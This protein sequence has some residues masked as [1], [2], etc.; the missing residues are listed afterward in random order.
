[1][2]P[3]VKRLLPPASSSGA[4][5]STSTD[6]P[7]SA[8]ANAAQNAALPAPITTTSHEEGRAV[9]MNA[10]RDSLMAHRTAQNGRGHCG[11][12][13]LVHAAAVARN[14]NA[15]ALDLALAGFAAQLHDELVNLDRPGGTDRM[16]FRKQA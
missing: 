10:R 3:A 7:C 6:T 11:L 13:A 15:G 14:C 4:R 12:L 9:L 2:A 1:M 16:P 5:S 8:A